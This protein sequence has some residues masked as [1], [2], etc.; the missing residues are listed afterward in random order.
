MI[1]ARIRRGKLA[2]ALLAL[3][4]LAPLPRAQAAS[5]PRPTEG[6]GN[7]FYLLAAVESLDLDIDPRGSEEF[8]AAGLVPR[9]DEV[10]VLVGVGWVFRRPLRLDLTAGGWRTAI[11]HPGATC[12]L[13]RASA[14]LHV[15]VVESG[16]ASLE[17]TVSAGWLILN[18]EG[19]GRE[20]HVPGTCVGLGATG[21]L[22]LFGALGLGATYQYQLGKFQPKTFE[23]EGQEPFRAQPTARMHGVRVTLHLDL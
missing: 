10:G 18:Y 19:T 1:A 8:V 3:A 22:K 2:L 23:L 9:S 12:S 6:H 4:H 20:E 13:A 21:R 15:A 17:A 11:D 14:E 5:P 16:A 7:N